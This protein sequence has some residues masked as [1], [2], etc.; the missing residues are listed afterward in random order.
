MKKIFESNLNGWDESAN[1]INVYALE[2]D[3]E[4]NEFYDM[5]HKERCELFNVFDEHGCDIMPG[6]IYRTYDFNICGNFIVMT[7]TLALNV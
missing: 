6:G 3:R 7:E 1:K 4:W 5:T 2:S